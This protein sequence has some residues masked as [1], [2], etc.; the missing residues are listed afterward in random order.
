MTSE[1][2]SLLLNQHQSSVNGKTL[3]KRL[4][5]N[6]PPAVNN[7]IGVLLANLAQP[8]QWRLWIS[9]FSR[10][11][12]QNLAELESLLQY[13][14]SHVVWEIAYLNRKKAAQKLNPVEQRELNYLTLYHDS[15]SARRITDLK[16]KESFASLSAQEQRELTDLQRNL[17][18]DTGVPDQLLE[19]LWPQTHQRPLEWIHLN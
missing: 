18:Q 16:L 8:N 10:K 7:R 9:R 17:Y 4:S 19:L 3:E 12:K 2:F 13:G 15:P 6:Q 14:N 11:F 1:I 5:G